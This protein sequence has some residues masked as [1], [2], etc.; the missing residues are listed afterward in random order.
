MTMNETGIPSAPFLLFERTGIDSDKLLLQPLALL[1][2]PPQQS[3]NKGRRQQH[4]NSNIPSNPELFSRS[5]AAELFDVKSA[6]LFPDV[7]FFSPLLIFYLLRFSQI[8]S[9]YL[10]FHLCQLRC[11]VIGSSRRLII[12]FEGGT[13]NYERR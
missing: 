7:I 6:F 1:L 4:S 12:L 11:C 9:H 2:A 13:I 8:F 3:S 5:L 10:I